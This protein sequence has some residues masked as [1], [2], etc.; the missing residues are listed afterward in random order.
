MNSVS[1]SALLMSYS[2]PENRE[3][4]V[5]LFEMSFGIGQILGPAFGSLLFTVG[6]FCAP[7]ATCAALY[8]LSWPL[9]AFKL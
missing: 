6:G 7:F 5:G 8:L 4:N 9:I 1:C 3:K 2:A